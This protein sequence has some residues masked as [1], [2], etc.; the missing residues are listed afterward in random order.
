MGVHVGQH[1]VGAGCA[2]AGKA[3]ATQASMRHSRLTIVAT[4]DLP[5]M[6]SAGVRLRGRLPASLL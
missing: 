5:T 1:V 3:T 4:Q 6:P 2:R